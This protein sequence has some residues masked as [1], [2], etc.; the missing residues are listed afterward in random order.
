MFSWAF[1]RGL[2]PPLEHE[3]CF[4]VRIECVTASHKDRKLRGV[5]RTFHLGVIAT[6]SIVVG[7]CDVFGVGSER[8]LVRVDSV[9][10]PAMVALGDTLR[11]TFFGR[12]GP[13][14]CSRLEHVAKHATQSSLDIEFHGQRDE[15]GNC[16]QMPV[17]LRHEESVLPPL[18]DP[19]HVRVG[20]PRGVVLERVI[21]IEQ[22]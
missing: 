18:R 22:P 14:G 17:E 7:A 15:H 11:M 16:T 4:Q 13:D 21:R 9:S 3:R 8:F 20:Q 6:A 2:R 12:V 10:A 19:F 5:V 1:D